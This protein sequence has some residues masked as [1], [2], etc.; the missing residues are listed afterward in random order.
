MHIHIQALLAHY[1]YFAVFFIL[2]FEMIGIPFPAETTLTLS[3]IEWEK[4]NLNLTGLIIAGSIGNILGSCIAYAIGRY[5]GRYVILRFGKWIGITEAR[6]NR[7]EALFFKYRSFVVPGGKF[8]AGIRILIPYL[9]GINKMNFIVFSIYNTVSALLWS[10]F[11]I[12]LGRYIGVIWTTYI[13]DLKLWQIIILTAVLII[14]G[15]GLVRLKHQI[16]KKKLKAEG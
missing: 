12:V 5:L 2:L 11:F 1:G 10:A 9:A 8:I 13:H 14:V 16:M 7:A 15:I 3:G 6:L 4:G